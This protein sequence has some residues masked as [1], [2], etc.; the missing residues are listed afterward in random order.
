MEKDGTDFKKII[1]Q[2]R[3]VDRILEERRK[4]RYKQEYSGLNFFQRLWKRLAREK[5]TEELIDKFGCGL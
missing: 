4:E 3:E 2:A 1:E 5:T